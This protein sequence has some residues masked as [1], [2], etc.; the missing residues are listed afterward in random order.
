MEQILLAKPNEAGVIVTDKQNDFLFA[1]N[2]RM[3]E[4]EDLSANICLMAR[5]QPT[6]HSSDVGP[7]HDSAFVSK[8][9]SS[10]IN[11]NEEQMYPTHTKII[12]STIGDDQIDSNIIF[13]TPNRNVNSGSVEKDTH[14]PDLCAL[15]QLARNA[16]QEAEKQQLK[17]GLG[18]SNPYTLKQAISQCLKLYLSSSLGNSEIPLN[19]RDNE[20]TLDDA[21][22]SQ[23]K[24]KEKINDPI[25]VANK[26]NCWTVDYQQINALYKDFVP[27]KV[28]SAEQKYFSS[29]L[30]PSDKNSNATASI[31]TSM[32]R[33]NAASS[34]RRSMNRDSHNKNSVLANSKNSVKKV[35]VYVRK[36][37]Q[38]DNTFVNV[39]SNKENV[40]DVDVAN[41]SKA[42]NLLCVFYTTYVVLK[43]RFSEN[44]AQSKTLDTTFV[45]FKSKIDVG[46]AS[47]AKN[48]VVHIVLLIVDSGF[49]KHT[50]GD[51]SLLRNF[52]KKFMGTVHF[53]NDNF[54]AITGYV[55][56]IQGNIT[57]CHVY[58]VEG[59]GHN[60]FSV[61]QF[62]DGDLEVAFRSKTCYVQNLKGDDFLTGGRESNLYTISISDMLLLHQLD[63]V[64]GLPKFKYEKDHIC[65]ACEKGKSKK[66]SHPTKLVPNL[67][68]TYSINIEEHQAPPVETTS[69]EQTSPISLTESDELHQEDSADFDGNSQSVHITL[70]VMKQ[71]SPLQRP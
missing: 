31:S 1:E 19:V 59:L 37:K 5:I 50:M 27:Q 13:D 65:S 26:Q 36:N 29:S 58:Y 70:Q 53:G 14:V 6:N 25:A 21:S 40:I 10:F 35:A 45:V 33:T 32:Q 2:S 15:E 47:K 16:Y 57:I 8:V 55:D 12:N 71:L 66:A 4:I 44:P 42:K 17:H 61:G 48:K 3:E 24:V 22:K 49:S 60:L 62:C 56:Y 34:V 68:S 54:A 69:D 11:E 63:L 28:L 67:P 18:Y 38:K 7:R 30:I 52:I 9:Q 23:Q 41:A 64:N 43:T 51:R 39:I 20:N 46:S